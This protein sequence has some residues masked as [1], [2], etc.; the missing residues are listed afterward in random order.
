MCTVFRALGLGPISNPKAAPAADLAVTCEHYARTPDF[1][2]TVPFLRGAGMRVRRSADP[3]PALMRRA[4]TDPWCRSLP[5]L[6]LM[7][8]S[9]WNKCGGH[10]SPQGS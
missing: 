9:E 2:P 8:F 7:P 10:R 5:M 4:Q 1:A 6:H 3:L